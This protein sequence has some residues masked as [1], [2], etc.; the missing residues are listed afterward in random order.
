MSNSHIQ[1]P[2]ER[3]IKTAAAGGIIQ[4]EKI[5]LV[6]SKSLDTW[7]IPG[8]IQEVGETI[9]E[10]VEREIREELG[11]D[12]VAKTLVSV[13]SGTQWNVDYPD[14]GKIQQ[15][16]FFFLMNGKIGHLRLQE[17]EITKAKFFPLT[18]LPDNTMPCCRQ[19]IQ[20]LQQFNGVT[21]LR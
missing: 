11:L 10:T 15:V 8:G 9:Q 20:D 13:Y 12:F 7:Q 21:I 18:A 4:D 17:S 16:L 19:K 1:R 6:Y 14:G 3:V 5:L 2:A